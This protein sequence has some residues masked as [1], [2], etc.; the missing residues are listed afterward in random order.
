MVCSGMTTVEQW[1][2]AFRNADAS[3][4]PLA[5]KVHEAC[6]LGFE[7]PPRATPALASKPRKTDMDSIVTVERNAQTA[8]GLPYNANFYGP[9]L[10]RCHD[11]PTEETSGIE[12]CA[13]LTGRGHMTDLRRHVPKHAGY[14]RTAVSTFSRLSLSALQV[15]AALGLFLWKDLL[16]RY[17][18]L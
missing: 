4:P 15:I 7:F 2:T 14:F 17:S 9:L 1:L 10:P 6:W 8:L 16:T 13:S 18:L 5:F 12:V 3:S 11:G